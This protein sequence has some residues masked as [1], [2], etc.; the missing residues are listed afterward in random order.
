MLTLTYDVHTGTSFS[1]PTRH[2]TIIYSLSYNSTLHK[3]KD[4]ESFKRLH[5]TRDEITSYLQEEWSSVLHSTLSFLQHLFS[6]IHSIYS[7]HRNE[8]K[9]VHNSTKKETLRSSSNDGGQRNK[10]NKFYNINSRCHDQRCRP[11][12]F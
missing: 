11:K 3:G 7:S 12:C 1:A 10:K 4:K 5:C 2:D 9:M 8:K 6:C